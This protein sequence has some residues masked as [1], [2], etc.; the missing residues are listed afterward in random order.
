MKEPKVNSLCI[1]TDNFI[2]K[3]TFVTT[4]ATYTTCGH[5]GCY[6]ATRSKL[7]A[8]WICCYNERHDMLSVVF[9]RIRKKK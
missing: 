4:D 1:D 3:V 7:C 9:Q 5:C 2:Y 8:A 6:G